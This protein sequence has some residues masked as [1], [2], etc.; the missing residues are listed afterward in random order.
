MDGSTFKFERWNFEKENS[1]KASVG[2][3]TLAL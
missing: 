2:M 3:P 1:D